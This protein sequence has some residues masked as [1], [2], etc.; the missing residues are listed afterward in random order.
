[1]EDVV[2]DPAEEGAVLQQAELR[3]LSP[4][5]LLVR[6]R[7]GD[8]E[9]HAVELADHPGKRLE[10][11]LEALLVDEPPDEQDELLVRGR[12][13]A[14]ELAHHGS[15]ERLKVGRIDPVRDHRDAVLLD[16]VDVAD[17]VAHV[18]GAG[19]HLVRAVRHPA[20]DPVDVALRVLV[21]PALVAAE[22]GRVDRHRERCAD[23]LREVIAGD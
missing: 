19:D 12:E 15:V 11:D 13:P 5:L 8:E 7:S 4:K 9:A 1:V 21:D 16:V 17:V 20:L 18:G 10:R 6:A 2:A 14:A 22:L 23:A 3:R